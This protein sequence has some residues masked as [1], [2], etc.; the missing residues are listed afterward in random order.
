MVVSKVMKK[1]FCMDTQR[2]LLQ[3]NKN[4]RVEWFNTDRTTPKQSL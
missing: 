4:E 3:G 2:Y 1:S